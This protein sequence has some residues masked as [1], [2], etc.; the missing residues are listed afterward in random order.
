VWCKILIE[1]HSFA[2]GDLV[3]P[4]LFIEK[5]VFSLL[6]I[7]GIFVVNYLTMYAYDYFWVSS[8][9]HW[10]VFRPIECCSVAQ[11]CPS[12]CDPMYYSTP[13]FPVLHHLPELAETHVHWVSGAIQPSCPLSSPSS[14]TFS[15][16][17][18]Q[19]L[20][21]WVSSSHQ[22]AKVLELPILWSFQWI[23]RIDFL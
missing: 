23:F 2:C 6:Y 13:G 20:F 3:F 5:T 17:Q 19:C 4:T 15:L 12:L 1:F 7:L 16:S 14:P 8:L 11:L 21:Q 10:S 18:H 9:F 22:M